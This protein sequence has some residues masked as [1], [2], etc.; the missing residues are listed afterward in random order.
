V[1]QRA[2]SVERGAKS[3]ELGEGGNEKTNIEHRTSNDEWKPEKNS[4]ERRKKADS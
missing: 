4:V 3:G 1:E 2:E